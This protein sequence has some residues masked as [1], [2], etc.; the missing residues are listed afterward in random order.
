MEQF[1]LLKLDEEIS[2]ETESMETESMDIMHFIPDWLNSINLF[3]NDSKDD[4]NMGNL[5]FSSTPIKND[6]TDDSNEEPT[7][8]EMP[9][10]DFEYLANLPDIDSPL[11]I[12]DILKAQ[13]FTGNFGN[14]RELF[15]LCGLEI[16]GSKY[17]LV[18]SSSNPQSL[19][20]RFYGFIPSQ[21]RS[22]SNTL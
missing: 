8:N 11:E 4:N 22:R 9:R 7:V 5:S 17:G 12:P 18:G 10:P 19:Q 15:S 3:D 21:Y 1:S 6:A 14:R 16:I 2:K 13:F 20:V